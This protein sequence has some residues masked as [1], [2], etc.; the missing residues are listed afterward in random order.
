MQEFLLSHLLEIELGL[1]ELGFLQD[2]WLFVGTNLVYWCL[3]VL[4]WFH[5]LA[6]IQ[7]RYVFLEEVD[8]IGPLLFVSV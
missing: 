2:L 6:M 1:F 5:V 7:V 4:F 3:V 8:E